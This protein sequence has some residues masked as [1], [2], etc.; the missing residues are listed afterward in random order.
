METFIILF[1]EATPGQDFN[2][3]QRQY[4]NTYIYMIS[5]AELLIRGKISLCY[6][7]KKSVLDWFNTSCYLKIKDASPCNNH[8]DGFFDILKNCVGSYKSQEARV[9]DCM[10]YANRQFL[11]QDKRKFSGFIDALDGLI[12]KGIFNKN[13][14]NGFFNWIGMGSYY[15]KISDSGR[16]LQIQLRDEI[17][18]SLLE[19]HQINEFNR[20]LLGLLIIGGAIHDFLVSDNK[21]LRGVLSKEEMIQN[22][23]R[24]KTFLES[25]GKFL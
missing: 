20:I 5:I 16:V 12:G 6:L 19:S 7:E 21:Y 8:L 3:F 17:R 10:R 4:T 25:N 15:Y 2:F 24:L 11:F 9:Y 23:S 22:K 14:D 18:N 13:I 1:Y